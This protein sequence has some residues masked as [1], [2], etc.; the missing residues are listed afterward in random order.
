MGVFE[1][2]ETNLSTQLWIAARYM[3]SLSLLL[4]PLFIKRK[5]RPYFIFLGYVIATSIILTSIFYW[6]FFPVCF[7]ETVG[8]TPFKIVSEYMISLILI[9][10]IGFVFMNRQEF[11]SKVLQW[12]TW[13]ILTT[14]ISELTFTFYIHAYGF[15]NMVGHFFKIIS[16][17]FI[18]KALIETGL[19]QPYRLLF[20]NL[21]KNEEALQDALSESKQRQAEISA[22]LE[23][24]R[25]ILEHHEFN[26]SAQSIF[27]SCKRLIRATAGYIALLSKDG[28]ENELLFLD[29]G[30]LPCSVDPEFPMPIRGLREKTY[31]YGQTVFENAFA[32]S[33]YITFLP[34]GHVQLDNVLFAPLTIDGK[35]IGLLGLANKPGGFSENDARLATAF[36]E[37][38]SVAL[39]NSRTLESLETSEEQLRNSRDELEIRVQQRTEELAKLN[40]EL[41]EQS[42]ILDSFF[43]HTITPLVLLDK[44]FNFIRVNEAYAKTCQRDVSEFPG[45]N[46][47]EFYPSDARSIFEQVVKTKTPYQAIARP[48]VFPDHPEWGETYWDWTLTPI[49]DVEGEVEYLVLSLKDVS[50]RK[51]AEKTVKAERERFN[52]VL[53]ILPAYLVLLTRDYHVPFANRYFRER[54]GEA[55][56][57][58]CF[59]YLFGRSE[60]CETC[61]TY[62]VLKSM[63]PHR[64]EWTGPDSRIYDVFDFPFIDTDSSPLILE[65]GFD[66]TERKEI[67]KHLE[68]TNELLNLF[69]KMTSRK[70]YLNSALKLIQNWSGCQCA[71][72]R[73]L[74]SHRNIPYETYMGFSHEFWKSENWLSIQ[75]HQC[76][77]IRVIL[78]EIDSQ[79]VNVMTPAGSFCCGNM[80]SFFENLSETEKSRYRGICI[81]NGFLS[82]AIIPIRY[83]EK[84]IGAIHLA[85]KMENKLSPKTLEFIESITPMIGETFIRFNLEE[86]VK[87]SEGRLRFL[88]SELLKVQENERKRIAREIHDGIGQTLAALKFSLESKL[89]QVDNGVVPQGVSL[90]SIISLTQS[91]IEE[92]RRIQMDLHPS[93][94]DDLGI[95]ATLGWFTREYQKIYSHIRIE[96]KTTLEEKDVPDSLKIVLYRI[97]Q[98]ALNNIAKHSKANL[99]HLSLAKVDGKIELMIGDNGR[100]F[101]LENYRKGLGLTSMRERTEL[102]GGSFTIESTQQAG[103]MIR[104]S[105]P[106]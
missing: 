42:R 66:I 104:A 64:W 18:Y 2:S 1:V 19:S 77:C 59:E 5:L 67:Q 69:V 31:R 89:S 37:L 6:N 38:A 53:E 52:N 46:H 51:R 91:G 17:Y 105:W 44:E 103:T 98:E 10:A 99:V 28:K 87:E 15:L 68:A 12:I 62:T 92:A 70:E 81:Q 79:E 36:G 75:E 35:V 71:G 55:H 63:A 84:I 88:S 41:I 13:S 45:H 93:V 34:K 25:T 94:L 60:P 33:N 39:R 14:I 61:E 26:V 101:D 16:F 58:R 8:L 40:K 4:A 85:D 54:F 24:A 48:F 96:R 21:K 72:I 57:M 78:G 83:R 11:D 32:K 86:E 23:G 56:G 80:V 27:D 43:K 100:G 29:S 20:V 95:L 7:I 73:V 30:G 106:L 102:S 74:D 97:I 49:L 3:E 82:V 90:E 50:E 9:A 22:L 47:F 65:M 76:A